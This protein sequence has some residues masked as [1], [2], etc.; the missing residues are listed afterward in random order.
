MDCVAICPPRI[1][2][3]AAR[4]G[5]ERLA[6]WR[7][8]NRRT[9]NERLELF[10]NELRERAPAWQIAASG[11]Y[12]AYLRHPFGE[13]SRDVARRLAQQHGILCLAGEMFG[14][15]QEAFLR[16]AFANLDSKRI[17]ELVSRLAAS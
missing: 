3:E 14:P 2:Q 10:R 6:D 15:G 7:E 11:A 13:S 12:F 17:P 9:M 1:G 4:F 8:Q 5:L 16:V